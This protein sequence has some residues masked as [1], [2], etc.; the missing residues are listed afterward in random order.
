MDFYAQG[1]DGSIFTKYKVQYGSVTIPTRIFRIHP[2]CMP[3]PVHLTFSYFFLDI[4]HIAGE[5]AGSLRQSTAKAFISDS[6]LLEEL[7]HK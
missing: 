2:A 1:T 7:E 4:S 3:V 5:I 6:D